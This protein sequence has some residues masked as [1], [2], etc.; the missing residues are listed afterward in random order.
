M[1]LRRLMGL[2]LLMFLLS[3]CGL[4][5]TLPTVPVTTAVSTTISQPL[6]STLQP[7]T[8]SPTLRATKPAQPTP[9]SNAEIADWTLLIYMNADNNLELAGLLDMNEMEMAGDSERVNV[10]VQVD[11]AIGESDLDG[12]WTETRRY[13]M[14]GDDDPQAINAELLQ[15]LGEGNM[16]DPRALA[17]FLQWGMAAYPANKYA[18]VLWNHGVGW[19]GISFDEDVSSNEGD[20]I[21]YLSLDE[22]DAA[23]AEGLAGRKL[24]LI[25]FDACLMGQL[26]VLNAIRPYAQVAVGSEELTPGA[27]W[28]YEAL[29]RH[30]YANPQMDAAQLGTQ[31]V[32]D[33]MAY[34]RQNN[35]DDFVTM[36]AIDLTQVGA[37]TARVEQ[38]AGQLADNPQEALGAVGDA[39]SGAESFARVYAQESDP[40]AATDLGDFASILAQRSVNEDIVIAAEEVIT[41]VSNAVITQESG[42]GLSNSQGIAVYFPRNA[43]SY[44]DAYGQQTSLPAW[45]RFLQT[46]HVTGRSELSA[47]DVNL[48]NR[49]DDV[50]GVQNPA[51]L[52][53]QTIGR[54]IEEVSIFVG[55]VAENGRIRLLEYDRLIPEP[56]LLPDGA[57]IYQWRDGVHDDFY[58]WDTQVTYLYD[59]L[60]NGDFVIMW[61][62]E[63][64]STLF[65]V[66]G[67][68]RRTGAS[69]SVAANL[70]F[71]HRT[72]QLQRVWSL[73][74]NESN[75]P[76][77]IIP[78]SGD[79]FQLTNYYQDGE[80]LIKEEG[81]SLVFN[82]E[83]TLDFEWRPLSNGNYRVGIEAENSANLKTA[84]SIPLTVNNEQ[85][86]ADYETYLDPYLGFQFNYPT[87]WYRPRYADGLLYT[88]N[89]KGTTQLL[90]TVY[91]NLEEAITP[92]T[93][94]KQ[95][96]NQFG[97]VTILE[98][99]EQQM[100]SV[101]GLKTKYRYTDGNGIAHRG[102][103]YTF[104]HPNGTG[105][106]IDLDGLLADEVGV[107]DTAVSLANSWQFVEVGIG[108]RP[109]RW[110]TLDLDTFSVAQPANFTYQQA[111]DWERFSGGDETFV[112]LRVTPET[113]PASDVLTALLRDAAVGLAD[114]RI[115]QDKITFPLDDKVWM[116]S[117]FAYTNGAGESIA[118]FIMVRVQNGQEVVAWAE[119]LA[120]DVELETA[121]FLPMIAD[122]TL[123]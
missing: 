93:L 102:I 49:L 51:F 78:L 15:R 70:V 63:P 53:F 59:D 90:V 91:P 30:L 12:D 76:A 75:A 5:N 66:A 112:A 4:F 113:R 17:D 31:I 14:R 61:P 82:A 80:R 99:S 83:A 19:Q 120:R 29:L 7:P 115:T 57:E 22:L 81:T 92:A 110:A 114:F 11:R 27:G 35:L 62:T 38:L 123:N 55:R 28:D 52:E 48:Y 122:L 39:R 74:A 1:L 32:T 111:G 101:T 42:A 6:A 105:Y 40:F 117:S 26:D 69:K 103:F 97:E 106:V 21:D 108:P 73:Q 34:Y 2:L 84:V 56:T 107:V 94:Q 43:Q 100:G 95:T 46:Y 72:G 96:L 18:L 121:V 9:T 119:G 60:G 77:E 25:G 54:S 13:L 8:P 109:G 88:T 104:V 85:L 118:G 37:V 3:A 36:T 41:A 20:G 47:P 89:P 58:I 50:V 16:G 98:Q 71:D 44:D 24:D 64:G 65:T 67:Q 23:L 45:N 68:L 79:T 33:F 10:L 87:N 116:R 86:I